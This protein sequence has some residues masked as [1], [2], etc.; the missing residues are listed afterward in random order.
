MSASEVEVTNEAGVR[1][2]ALNRPE[3]KNGLTDAVNAALIEALDGAASDKAIRCVVV[4]G[5]GGN[6]CSGLDL[7]TMAAGGMGGM[8]NVEE[9]MR[10]YFHGLIRAVRRV[11][12]PV[13][14]LVDGAAVG[15]GC[16]LAL[17]CD[18][19]IG[20]ERTR[21]GE[22]FVKR[23]LMP[24]GGGTWSLPRLVGV[25]KALEMMFTGD[26]VGGDEAH[27]IGLVTRVIPSAEA[28][29]QTWEFAKRLAAGPPLVHAWIK[30][31]VYAAQATDLD[32]APENE[33]RGQMQL[34]RSKDFFEG[35]S[36]FLQKRDP[37]FKGE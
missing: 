30:R 22:V 4:T 10:K 9:H 31:A 1:W 19:R 26:M 36:A 37:Q 25:G 17:A 23:G 18:L 8:D 14:A 24:D 2:I 11:E 3:S 28:E 27:R 20:T 21:F 6:F 29:Q 15:Y 34:L 12:K 7:K 32:A 16:D 35:V 13:V 5:K 33:V